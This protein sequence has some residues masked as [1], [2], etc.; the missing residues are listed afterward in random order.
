ME[1]E[2]ALVVAERA[3]ARF[4]RLAGKPVRK[5][6][7]V[8]IEGRRRGIAGFQP[9]VVLFCRA[10]LVILLL[11]VFAAPNIPTRPSWFTRLSFGTEPL[12]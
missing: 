12:P 11:F 2:A 3:P 8:V 5:Q 1:K 6:L 4:L 10:A 7:R 9:E